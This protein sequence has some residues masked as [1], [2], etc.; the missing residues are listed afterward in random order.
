MTVM[1]ANC[2]TTLSLY[3]VCDPDMNPP[4]VNEKTERPPPLT[5]GG[6]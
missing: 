6:A 1:T 3:V 2:R 4:L 5:Q